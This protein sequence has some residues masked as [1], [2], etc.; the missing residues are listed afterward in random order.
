[1]QKF[2]TF[3]SFGAMNEKSVIFLHFSPLY[4]CRTFSIIIDKDQIHRHDRDVYPNQRKGNNDEKTTVQKPQPLHP[5]RAAG[6]DNLSNILICSI[7]AMTRKKAEGDLSNE[8]VDLCTS[9]QWEG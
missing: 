4:I 3:L 9:E 5:D 1:M 2:D 8:S 6:K 7:L